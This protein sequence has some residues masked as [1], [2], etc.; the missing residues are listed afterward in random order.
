MEEER[1]GDEKCVVNSNSTESLPSG[2]GC[3][4]RL[5]WNESPEI[6]SDAHAGAKSDIRSELSNIAAACYACKCDSEP[7]EQVDI[8]LRPPPWWNIPWTSFR[9]FLPDASTRQDLQRTERFRKSNS[10]RDCFIIDKYRCNMAAVASAPAPAAAAVGSGISDS[11][12][13]DK[14]SAVVTLGGSSDA[15]QSRASRPKYACPT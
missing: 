10:A 2:R 7:S 1:G 9:H 6:L 11:H 3:S 4:V 15:D 13:S 5:S 8:A 12:F 14:A